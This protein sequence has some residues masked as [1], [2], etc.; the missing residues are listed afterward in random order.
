[1]EKIL[2]IEEKL[3][4][5]GFQ[6]D[7]LMIPSDFDDGDGKMHTIYYCEDYP[8]DK[9]GIL[10]P[11]FKTLDVT[12]KVALYLPTDEIMLRITYSYAHFKGSGRYSAEL[13]HLDGKWTQI[14]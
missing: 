14:A 12:I 9:F 13:R 5:Y 11:L 8:T 4:E 10:T 7:Y 6:T 3:A 1:M 2:L